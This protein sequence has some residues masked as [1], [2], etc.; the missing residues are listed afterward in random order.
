MKKIRLGINIDHIATIRNARGGSHPCPILGAK[1]A[2]KAGADGITAHLREDRRHI[3]D[4]DIL[5]LKEEIDLP[6]N[7]EMAA[8]A[9]MIKIAL[10]IEPNAVCLV[11]ENRQEITTE[12]GLDIIKNQQN[13]AQIITELKTKKIRISLFVDANLEQILAAKKIGA[14]I[15]EI[16][17]GKYCYLKGA[18]Q[19]AEF[20]IIAKAIEYADQL[21]LECHAGHGLNFETAKQIAKIP[22]IVELNIGHFLIGEAVFIG[23]EQAIIKM[24]QQ[25]EGV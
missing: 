24:R 4:E 8:T 1:I 16:H 3:K 6:L 10:R 11:P 5:R 13:L 2:K 20:D 12:G 25:I 23:L 7:F 22:Q 9:E 14:N 19:K 21:G 17:T 18:D 15:V